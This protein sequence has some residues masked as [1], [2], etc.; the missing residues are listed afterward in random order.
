MTESYIIKIMYPL[1][2]INILM[3]SE[4]IKE[5]KANKNCKAVPLSFSHQK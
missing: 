1:Q 4:V 3:T 5:I 2:H